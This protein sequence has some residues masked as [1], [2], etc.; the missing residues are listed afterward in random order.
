M[1]VIEFHEL[2]R[3]VIDSVNDWHPSEAIWC[4]ENETKLDVFINRL[5]SGELEDDRI[6]MAMF[7]RWEGGEMVDPLPEL[8]H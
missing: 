2:D 3:Q 7:K 4:E 1:T 5:K 8:I 6:D